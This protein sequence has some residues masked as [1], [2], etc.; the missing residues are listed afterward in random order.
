MSILARILEFESPDEEFYFLKLEALW[1]LI[2]LSMCDTDDLKL[3]LMSNFPK[4]PTKEITIDKEIVS[5]DFEQGQS[6]IIMKIDGMMQFT[7]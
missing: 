5:Q 1:V 4:D 7:L 2:N 3:I 6:D